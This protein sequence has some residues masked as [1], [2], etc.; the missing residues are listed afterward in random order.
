MV[1]IRNTK[2]DTLHYVPIANSTS[3]SS[4]GDGILSVTE[5]ILSAERV[6][7]CTLM[8]STLPIMPISLFLTKYF[9]KGVMIGAIKG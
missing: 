8:A 1:F 9:E 5:I 6:R 3:V 2:M 7:Y 4:G